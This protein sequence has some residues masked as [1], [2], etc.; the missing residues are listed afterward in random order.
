MGNHVQ[1]LKRVFVANRG[2][3]AVRIIRACRELDL[4]VVVGVSE[5]D[6]HSLPARLADRA[7]CIGPSPSGQSYLRPE[8]LITAAKGAGCDAIHPG[9]GFLSEQASFNQACHDNGI[10]FIGPSVDAIHA[11]GDKLSSIALAKEA[12]VPVIPGFGPLEHEAQA[13]EVAERIG[14]P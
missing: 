4:E 1:T 5:A 8:L 10:T 14:Y 3:I 2:E 9:Y 11:M 6:V 12:G 13:L 7:I